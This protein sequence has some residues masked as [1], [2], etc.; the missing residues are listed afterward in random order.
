MIAAAGFV[1]APVL[2]TAALYLFQKTRDWKSMKQIPALIL[3]LQPWAFHIVVPILAFWGMLMLCLPLFGFVFFG[4]G[5]VLVLYL[6][7]I[8][9]VACSNTPPQ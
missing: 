6:S 7:Q 3:K 1:K 9:D 8:I 4:G 2:F 5:I